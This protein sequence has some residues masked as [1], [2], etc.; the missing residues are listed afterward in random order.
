MLA[1]ASDHQLEIMASDGH[2]LAPC[3]RSGLTPLIPAPWQQPCRVVRKG[4]RGPVFGDDT[5]SP[6]RLMLVTRES[7]NPIPEFLFGKPGDSGTPD[8]RFG[9]NLNRE[10]ETPRLGFPIR[11]DSESG[12]GV[13]GAAGRGFPGPEPAG[14]CSDLTKER[15][16]FRLDL[17]RA[18][19][20]GTARSLPALRLALRSLPSC[21]A[22]AAPTRTST[23]PFPCQ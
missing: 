20:Q 1:S 6:L 15:P 12:I 2:A 13:P 7:E 11:P 8:A 23:S 3:F 9:Q 18:H 14:Q 17:T 10:S 4:S 5:P 22:D 19:W 21:H 16:R